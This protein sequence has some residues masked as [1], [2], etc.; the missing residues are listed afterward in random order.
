M[1]R[2][3]IIGNGLEARSKLSLGK[4]RE[5]QRHVQN[6]V[7]LRASICGYRLNLTLFISHRSNDIVQHRQRCRLT[8][9]NWFTTSSRLAPMTAIPTAHTRTCDVCG[10]I[11]PSGSAYRTHKTEHRESIVI[12]GGSMA[13]AFHLVESLRNSPSMM[14]MAGR[15]YSLFSIFTQRTLSLRTSLS[16]TVL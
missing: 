2:V 9:S 6:P 12:Q 3:G 16:E 1:V 5:A 11:T 4:A 13:M 14:I 7:Q 8:S 15:N 10:K